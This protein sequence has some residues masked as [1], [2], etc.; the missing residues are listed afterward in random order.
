[1]LKPKYG[2]MTESVSDFNRMLDGMNKTSP[3]EHSSYE[4]MDRMIREEQDLDRLEKEIIHVEN[5]LSGSGMGISKAE[6]EALAESY[7]KAANR[8]DV[9]ANRASSQAQAAKKRGMNP[10]LSAKFQEVEKRLRRKGKEYKDKHEQLAAKP[11]MV[12]ESRDPAINSQ[13]H[14]SGSALE[15]FRVLAGIEEQVAMPRDAGIFGS[16]RHNADFDEMAQPFGEAQAKPTRKDL[17]TTHD[18]LSRERD[19]HYGA[20]DSASSGGDRRA[21]KLHAKLHAKTIQKLHKVRK[22]KAK[23]EDI[24][25][26]GEARTKAQQMAGAQ[27][28]AGQSPGQSPESVAGKSKNVLRKSIS[29]NDP[30]ETSARIA[31]KKG[32][33][34]V[35]ML[36]PSLRRDPGFALSNVGGKQRPNLPE[37][38]EFDEVR[39]PVRKDMSVTARFRASGRGISGG[40]LTDRER[41]AR[42]MASK[43]GQ[44][45]ASAHRKADLRQAIQAKEDVEYQEGG[46]SRRTKEYRQDVHVAKERGLAV[47]PKDAPRI[48]KVLDRLPPKDVKKLQPGWKTTNKDD[49]ARAMTKPSES[50]K[51]DSR[52]QRQYGKR[53]NIA[54]RAEKAVAVKKG[55]YDDAERYGGSRL[56]KYPSVHHSTN[57]AYAALKRARAKGK[58]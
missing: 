58:G 7:K 47:S 42:A 28:Q 52:R 22:L 11:N 8:F 51:K 40:A 27:A 14:S 46:G 25:P 21:A 55:H 30:L 19:A 20:W 3:L 39:D 13:Y 17:Q 10:A 18:E 1:M 57:K 41:K 32:I 34:R 43:H 45:A 54:D 9:A 53:D 31:A 37:D 48:K 38:E 24:E 33:G 15:R 6:R 49:L 26:F 2:N 29:R 23:A 56:E 16:T 44:D 4:D 50:Q 36:A 5:V 35:K 12:A